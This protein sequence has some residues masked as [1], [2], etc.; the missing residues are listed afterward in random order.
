[1]LQVV[2]QHLSLCTCSEVASCLKTCSLGRQ[3][4]NVMQL[5]DGMANEGKERNVFSFDLLI[6]GLNMW[7]LWLFWSQILLRRSQRSGLEK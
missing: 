2:R 3:E 7:S 1:M 6:D 4:E 5:G